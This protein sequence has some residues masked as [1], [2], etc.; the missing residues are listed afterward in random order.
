MGTDRNPVFRIGEVPTRDTNPGGYGVHDHKG[1]RG[2]SCPGL[3]D[4]R[5][6]HTYYGLWKRDLS[7]GGRCP[8]CRSRN[9]RRRHREHRIYRWGCR[10]CNTIFRLPRRGIPAWAWIV[11][12]VGAVVISALALWW[13][14]DPSPTS[15]VPGNDPVVERRSLPSTT[16]QPAPTAMP[17]PTRTTP[18]TSA[19]SVATSAERSSPSTPEPAPPTAIS[20]VSATT[21]PIATPTYTVTPSLT[22]MPTA[23]PSSRSTPDPIPPTSSG[24]VPTTTFPTPT[25]TATAIPAP[26][27]HPTAIP[28]PLA[29]SLLL[30]ATATVAGYR[31]DGTADVALALT[32][33]NDGALPLEQTQPVA[34]SCA[35]DG[36]AVDGCEAGA[37]I[38]LPDGFGPGTAELTLRVPM[39]VATISVDYGG[40]TVHT[41]TMDVPER[42]VGVDR[43]IWECYSDR[44]PRED[45][46]GWTDYGCY[47]WMAETVEKWKTPSE[48]RVWTTGNENYIRAFRET[49]DEQLSP[50]L[51]LDF[52]WVE[53]EEDAQLVAHLGIPGSG[54][55]DD[56]WENCRDAWGCG[57]P[58]ALRD[59]QVLRGDLLVFHLYAHDR[60]LDDYRKLKRKLNGVF[61]HE[62]LH[63][64][65]PT[66][67]ADWKKV[68][69]SVMDSA[70][71]LSHMD[72]AI[73]RLHSHPLIRP[74]MNMSEVEPL[75]VFEDE[76]LDE[77][78]QE[79]PTSYDLLEYALTALQ[80][81]DAVR[82]K[83]R[84][85]WTGGGCDDR[86]GDGEWATLEVGRFDYPD[87]PRLAHFRDGDDRFFIFHSE[88]AEAMDGDGWRHWK[89]RDGEWSLISREEIWDGTGWWL[90][91][92]KLH[93]T[94]AE[95]L[96]YYDADDTRIV[97][98]S[99]GGITVTA[100][101]NPTELSDFGEM[102]EWVTLSLVIDE[103]T[104][105][106]RRFEWT[107]HT[108]ERDFCQDYFE[109]GGDIEYGIEMEIP[110]GVVMGT[111]FAVPRPRGQ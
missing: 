86:F 100:E 35:R 34:I 53:R 99:E 45:E 30:D 109:E 85:G 72:R 61:I 83:I 36:F 64:L 101:Y 33:R 42:I 11:V 14:I 70:D 103:D 56:R 71:S 73:L 46:H 104:H 23:E 4:S 63:A 28:T 96:W 77:P 27:G 74:G 17:T 98:H 62:A 7:R 80:R 25:T 44:T 18:G 38:E 51:N 102:D 89:E 67:H 5:S 93:H 22:A 2:T 78:Q 13:G 79:P 92:S 105:R 20:I 60:F 65:A 59:G 31:L 76:L 108:G 58:S 68:A 50:V 9:I 6:V 43:E 55:T 75:I 107:H 94:I 52:R 110:R 19:R 37:A 40:D 69:I 54:A 91:N 82:M 84:G 24:A 3:A 39:G 15:L 48:V 10:N 26:T 49:L 87:D 57:G 21:S 12:V 111:K 97:D 16:M 95:L 29:I 1:S 66:G 106:V 8:H 32:L 41:L 88:E 90:R 47:G 81:V